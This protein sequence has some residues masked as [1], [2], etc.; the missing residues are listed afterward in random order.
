MKI[1]LIHSDFIEF[2]AKERAIKQAEEASSGRME[3]CLVVFTAVEKRDENIPDVADKLVTEI[4]EVA[5]KVNT[6]R[7]VLYPYAHLSRDLASPGF[8]L[9]VLKN[10]E[11]LLKREYEVLRAP[12]GWYKSFTL[13]AKGHPLAELSREITAETFSK[14]ERKKLSLRDIT[15]RPHIEREKLKKSDH[16]IIGHDL[17]LYSFQEVAPGMTFLHP[18]GMIVRN[19]LID[20]WRK[21]HYRRGYKEINTPLILNRAIWEISGHWDHYKDNMF[22]TTIDKDEF[23]IK[24]MNCPGAIMVFNS[25]TRSYRDLPLRLAELGQVHRNELSGVLSGFFRLRYFTQDDA[26]IFVMPEQLENEIENVVDIA[27][28]FYKRFGLGYHVEL[29][30][31]PEKRMGPDE[32]W[33]KAENALEKALKEKNIKYKIN[34]GDGAFYGPKIDFH[35]KDSLDR[36]WQCATI[37][38]DFMMPERFD[39]NYIGEDNKPHRPVIIHRVIYGAIERFMGI[40]TEH[41]NGAFPVWLAPTQVRI[42]SFTDRNEKA[43]KGILKELIKNDLRADSD[44]RSSTV[45]YKVREAEVQKIPYIIVI[46]D[47]EEKNNTVAVRKRGSKPEFGVKLE[48]FLKNINKEIEEMV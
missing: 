34:P 20:F 28:Y 42:I 37:Q 18:N 24:P 9:D 41:Y 26:H 4:N 43:A 6:K 13:K 48:D 22:F 7:I 23:A 45:Q 47:K 40:L 35:I 15:K 16:R 25:A 21:E 17:D 10:A 3:E 39:V 30:T 14:P 11:Q 27:D 38:V 32:I 8:A 44:L 5:E 31:R 46:G 2:I 33:D 36:T 29:S 12:F 1:L 19:M